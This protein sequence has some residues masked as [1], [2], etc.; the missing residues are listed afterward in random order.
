MT[1][2]IV[3]DSSFSDVPSILKLLYDLG[4]PLPKT[5]I[6]RENFEKLIKEFFIDT[7]KKIL[8][9]EIDDTK[10]IGLVSIM[11]LSRLNQNSLEMYIPELIID[12]EYRNLGIGRQLINSCI[13][14]AKN[15]K[16]HRIR[17]ESANHRIDSHLFYKRMGFEK[18]A[19]SFTLNL[20]P[21]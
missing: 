16:C 3:R 10:I 12:K 21:N 17:L 8:V 13:V 7:K 6:E 11:F 1:Q 9:S 4:R 5:D 2:T 20:I 18:S 19:F 15:K 14:L